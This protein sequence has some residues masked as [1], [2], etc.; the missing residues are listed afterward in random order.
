[1][2]LKCCHGIITILGVAG[3]CGQCGRNCGHDFKTLMLLAK[4]VIC[5]HKPLFKTLGLLLTILAI[6]P[7]CNN[8][9]DFGRIDFDLLNMIEILCHTGI[10]FQEFCLH[11]FNCGR[12]FIALLGVVGDAV[13]IMIVVMETPKNLDV[14]AEIAVPDHC[15]NKTLGLMSTI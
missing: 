11:S 15:L 9:L 14:A 2:V 7:D 6:V 4:I 13:A 12:D 1:M 3:N 8:L 10:E 5:G